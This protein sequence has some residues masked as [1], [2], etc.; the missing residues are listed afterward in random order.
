MSYFKARRAVINSQ[1]PWILRRQLR[2]RLGLVGY[3]RLRLTNSNAMI[4]FANN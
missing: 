4:L 3:L 2:N 1:C